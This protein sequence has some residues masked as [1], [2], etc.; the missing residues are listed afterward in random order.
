MKDMNR[1]QFLGATAAAAATLGIAG[2][3]SSDDEDTGSTSGS[4]STDSSTEEATSDYGDFTV[5]MI[6]DTGGVNDQSFNQLAWEG[7]Q[8]LEE[9]TGI[10][11][12][13]TE[14]TQESDYATNL[15]R[16]VDADC[17]LIWGV[18][19]AMADAVETAATTNP[20]YNFAII[21]NSYD[22]PADNLTGVVFRS[23][24]AAFA[25]GYVAACTTTTGQVGFVGGIES[26]VLIAFEYGYKAGVA[27]A[28]SVNGTSV[29]VTAQY[30]E[31]F[32]D[33]AAGK[34][35]ANSQYT[36]GCDI[37]FACA[38]NAGNGVIEAATETGNLVI[39]VDSDQ[40][41]LA[42]DNMLTSVLKK[43]DEA[44]IEISLECANG[45]SIGGQNVEL[46]SSD[47][48]VGLSEHHDLMDDDVYEAAIGL[49]D[50]FAS[51]EI[52]APT[53]EDEYNEYVATL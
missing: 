12:S 7:L 43:V 9:E 29:E 51:G 40:Y 48:A 25:G 30:V 31:S 37:V 28:N 32:S 1:R 36:N 5:T 39:G 19:Y 18:G 22:D 42:P 24:E 23:E 4:A 46:G 11:V 49:I 10:E 21:D 27:Y 41:D 44:V 6:T 17:N 35:T 13:Y 34:A 14:S 50:Q 38:G 20:D 47:D 52:V 8:E 26:D 3:S 53:N 33:T 15:D 2:C 45:E 16:A